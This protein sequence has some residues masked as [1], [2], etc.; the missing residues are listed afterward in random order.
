MFGQEEVLLPAKFLLTVAGVEV[1]ARDAGVDYYHVVM[2]RHEVLSANGIGAESLYLGPEAM[3]TLKA[4]QSTG[5]AMLGASRT[6]AQ[7]VPARLFAKGGRGRRL[8]QRH[9]KNARAF[10]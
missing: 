8:V 3:K 7:D 1:D 10:A 2:D 6:A 4:A 9:V 5:P